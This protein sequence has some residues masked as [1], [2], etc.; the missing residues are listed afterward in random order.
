MNK[1]LSTLSPVLKEYME[2]QLKYPDAVICF[3]IGVFYEVYQLYDYP[4]GFAKLASEVTDVVL[5]RRSKEKKDSIYM[6]GFPSHTIDNYVKKMLK[7]GLQVVIVSQKK[8]MKNGKPFTERFLDRICSPGTVIENLSAE[9]SNYYASL[10]QEDNIIGVTLIDISTGE[11]QV[12]E[13]LENKLNDYLLKIQPSEILIT[14]E[15][16]LSFPVKQNVHKNIKQKT[17]DKLDSCGN[18]L[19]NF[20][21]LKAP[22]SDPKFHLSQL[23]LE[24]WRLG[25]LSFGNLINY[26][27]DI[28]VDRNLLMKMS[29]PKVF[30]SLM[31]LEI[32]LS[33]MESL[34]ITGD[35]SLIS[36]LDKCGTAMGRRLLRNWINHPLNSIEDINLRMDVVE[37]YIKNN[38]VYPQIKTIY[39]IQRLS[40]KIITQKIMP[41]E[42]GHIITSLKTSLEILKSEKSNFE[43]LSHFIEFIE[44][45]INLELIMLASD[46]SYDFFKGDLLEQTSEFYKKLKESEILIERIK[47]KYENIIKTKVHPKYNLKIISLNNL[48]QL[49]GTKGLKNEKKFKELGFSIDDRKNDFLI[50][51]KE[52]KESTEQHFIINQQYISKSEKTWMLFLKF[53]SENYYS[54]ILDT[55]QKI[56]EIDV[57]LNFAQI[58]Q[59]NNYVRPNFIDIDKAYFNFEKVR[60]PIIEQSKKLRESFVANDVSLGDGQNLM[61]LYGANSSGKSTLLRSVA[62]NIL[63]AHIG[64]FVSANKADMTTFDSI[65]TR[66]SMSDNIENGESTFVVEMKEFNY[67][68][69]FLNKKT[70]M[71]LDEIG[72]GTSAHEGE[73]IA[74]AALDY[75]SNKND[76]NSVGFFATHYHNLSEKLET[77]DNII[78]KHIHGEIVD[79]KMVFTRKI[80]DGAGNGS[81]GI[82]VAEICGL[83]NTIIRVAK[84][85]Q[86]KYASLV[87]SRYNSKLE[88]FICPICKINKVE[89]TNHIIEQKQGTVKKVQIDGVEKSVHDIANLELIC[90]SCH[91]KITYGKTN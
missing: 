74:F 70:L 69:N 64:C 89:E 32:P 5:T 76:N 47:D 8:T 61:C 58:S 82:A 78:I 18:I 20:Y 19:G 10:Y 9:K 56:A 36:I 35:N 85:Y 83:P 37:R 80:Q 71:L 51:E 60:H 17:I 79:N 66:M 49:A 16:N 59:N 53:I 50:T 23:G 42:F 67:I 41:H 11:V 86:T 63:M 1:I 27:S 81:Y 7:A 21:K 29:R 46:K 22:T 15:L 33:G 14:G 25:S 43:E 84:N 38:V 57:L 65:L 44:S 88:G 54:L 40:R 48:Q 77:Y 13:I 34:N 3:E 26:L 45:N 2:Y 52:W 4:L 68:L 90:A 30:N 91:H 87:K 62:L 31:T 72:R 6:A 28:D 39:D 73:A 75:I 24:R 12:S 55:A